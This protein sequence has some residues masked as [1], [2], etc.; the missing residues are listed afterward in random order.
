MPLLNNLN[1]LVS[2]LF[3]IKS[4]RGERCVLC[5]IKE[6]V[7]SLCFILSHCAWLITLGTLGDY[8]A[9]S[10]GLRGAFLDGNLCIP[11]DAIVNFSWQWFGLL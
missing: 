11:R 9:Y 1:W 4:L 6:M 5:E 8:G 2:L 10:L 7:S 3:F